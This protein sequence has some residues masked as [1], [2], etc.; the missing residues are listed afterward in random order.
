M[1]IVVHRIPNSKCNV[2]HERDRH[3]TGQSNTVHDIHSLRMGEELALKV[4]RC[5]FTKGFT[6]KSSQRPSIPFGG[7]NLVQRPHDPKRWSAFFL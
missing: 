2:T 3:L 6:M 4:E 7:G 5:F 1:Y